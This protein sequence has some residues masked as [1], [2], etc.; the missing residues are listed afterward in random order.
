MKYEII[1]HI[2]KI[3]EWNSVSIQFNEVKWYNGKPKYDLRKWE[4]GEPKKGITLEREDLETLYIALGR[5]LGYEQHD[6]K[7]TEEIPFI[8]NS[9][10]ENVEELMDY[11]NFIVYGAYEDCMKK[12]HDCQDITV[13]VPYYYN[14]K[15]K[16]IKL[17]ARKCKTCKKYYISNYQY[18]TLMKKGRI[19]CQVVSKKEYEEYSKE[20]EAG[21]LS[22]Q[23]IL[24]IV[25]YTVNS[26]DDYSDD[27]RHNVLK[28]AIA[29]E[30]FTK[31]KAIRH[32]SWLIKLNENKSNMEES[33]K[34]WRSD[35]DY[36]RGYNEKSH[37]MEYI[38]L[39]ATKNII[40]L[41]LFEISL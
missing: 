21:G 12:G 25:G 3:K 17:P 4:D 38:N 31:E 27:Y 40:T 22:E 6:K 26:N 13:I 30:I 2:S 16:E 28:Y 29:E 20:Q 19:L 10:E 36:L 18:N 33:V 5:E 23:S 41:K 7:E 37:Y 8:N 9:V 1:R 11:R 39:F 34:K 24:K 35:R 15:V 14:G 32:I